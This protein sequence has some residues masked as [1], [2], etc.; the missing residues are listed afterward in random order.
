VPIGRPVPSRLAHHERPIQV[1]SL[2]VL[3][4]DALSSVAYATED[5]LCTL[6]P[7]GVG[8][9]ALVTPIGGVVAVLQVVRGKLEDV[10][11]RN[12]VVEG[13]CWCIRG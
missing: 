10:R 7:A 8:V 5:I 12:L 6:I 3:L 11:R 1:T 4:S 13:E 2:A 9:T